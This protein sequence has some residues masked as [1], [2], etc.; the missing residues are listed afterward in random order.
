MTGPPV[1]PGDSS[2]A[3]ATSSTLDPAWNLPTS[4]T[5]QGGKTTIEDY[6]ALGRLIKVWLPNVSKAS[7]TTPNIAYTYI[8]GENTA[9]AVETQ[10]LRANLGLLTSY[11]IY[12]GFLRPRQTQALGPNGSRL[13]SDTFYDAQGKTARTYAAYQADGVPS[14]TVRHRHARGRRDPDRLR[15][16][17]T[18]TRHDRDPPGR[19]RPGPGEV[20]H[21]DQLLR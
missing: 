5:D 6:D 3:L 1:T 18:R 15:V 20:A 8:T 12:D 10:T 16:R 9:A 2:T 7:N 11:Q 17:R 19:W 14:A 21:D 4:Q 13:I